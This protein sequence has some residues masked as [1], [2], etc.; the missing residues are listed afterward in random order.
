MCTQRNACRSFG[1]LV[2]PKVHV[3]FFVVVYVIFF[4]FS[5]HPCSYE[6]A[7]MCTRR[8][9]IDR[10]ASL[11]PF[12]WTYRHWMPYRCMNVNITEIDF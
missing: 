4:F 2:E 7:Y 6:Y 8:L 9:H 10:A 1:L 12:I 11:H 3:Y 5:F